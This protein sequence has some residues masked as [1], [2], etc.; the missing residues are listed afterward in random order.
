MK[1]RAGVHS[2]CELSSWSKPS[3]PL[4]LDLCEWIEEMP[5]QLSVRFGVDRVSSAG[6]DGLYGH[7]HLLK[8]SEQHKRV[9]TH[10]RLSITCVSVHWGCVWTVGWGETA[11]RSDSDTLEWMKRDEGQTRQESIWNTN[12]SI[13]TAKITILV[14][15]HAILLRLTCWHKIHVD[16]KWCHTVCP[17]V[18]EHWCT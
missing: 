1:V 2:T 5:N 14:L 11:D 17:P 13:I 10:V 15:W 16:R 18:C 6:S 9:W 7:T 3:R 4:K 8:R 12:H